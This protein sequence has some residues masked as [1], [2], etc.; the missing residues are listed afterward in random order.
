MLVNPEQIQTASRLEPSSIEE[1]RRERMREQAHGITNFAT[2]PHSNDV[3]FCLNGCVFTVDCSSGDLRPV[4]SPGFAIDPRISHGRIAAVIERSVWLLGDNLKLLLGAHHEHDCFGLPDYLA[5]EEFSRNR[6]FWWSPD[7]EQL[8]VQYVDNSPVETWWISASDQPQASSHPLKYPAAGKPNPRSE[9]VI[10]N[11]GHDS[12]KLA[13][14]DFTPEIT[15]VD[16]SNDK[17]PYLIRIDW[18]PARGLLISSLDRAQQYLQVQLVDTTTGQTSTVANEHDKFWV[19]IVAGV[20]AWAP[21]SQ[22]KLLHTIDD[23]TTNTRRLAI[24]TTAFSPDDFLVSSVVAICEDH[25]IVTGFAEP[26]TQLVAKITWSGELSLLSDPTGWAT[27]VANDCVTVVV[28]TNLEDDRS[29]ISSLWGEGQSSELSLSQIKALVSGSPTKTG[30]NGGSASDLASRAGTI[31]FVTDSPYPTV[32]VWPRGFAKES[33]S[34]P[35]VMAPYGGPHGRRVIN[36]SVNL[37]ASDQWLADHGFAVVIVDGPGTP[38]QGPGVEK[39]VAGDL[40]HPVV[41]GQVAGLEFV[42]DK[43]GTSLNPNRVGIHGWSFGGYLAAAAVLHRPDVFKAAVA[44]APVTD[45]ALYDSAYSERYLGL[46]VGLTAKNYRA[47]SLLP[48]AEKLTRPLLLIHGLADDNVVFANTLQLSR[49]L[50]EAG[51]PHSVLPLAGV[52]HMASAVAVAENLEKL[53]AQF[54]VEHLL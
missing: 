6:G 54:F 30:R 46:P 5:A 29:S 44:G 26:L 34:L 43:F 9:L 49:A 14:A 48:A 36:G 19:E 2:D 13:K 47:T 21:Q 40:C 10:A 18:S 41:D 4:E 37:F 15:R 52:T 12:T 22:G 45:W 50:V 42:L 20:P 53:Q 51:R 25:A 8:L 17:H 1:E 27:A 31:D 38:G 35:V 24:D 16:W 33:K 28:Q 7:G 11:L 39:L 32:V 3:V 23:M